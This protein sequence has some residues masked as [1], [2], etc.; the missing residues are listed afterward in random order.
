MDEL[1]EL[2]KFRVSG[3]AA[4]SNRC[5]TGEF[6]GGVAMATL[7]V[8]T[9]ER[10]HKIQTY[11]INLHGRSISFRRAERFTKFHFVSETSSGPFNWYE[12]LSV[13]CF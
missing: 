6:P 8:F 13:T 10:G 7:R 11:L 1:I 12:N 3:F 9:S 2:K 4:Q 5:K